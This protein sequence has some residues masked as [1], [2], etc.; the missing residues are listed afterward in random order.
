MPIPSTIITFYWIMIWSQIHGTCTVFLEY[1]CVVTG[2][3]F[4]QSTQ[5]V[6]Y[7]KSLHLLQPFSEYVVNMLCFQKH[8]IYSR[9]IINFQ[10][11]ITKYKMI[12]PSKSYLIN[13]IKDTVDGIKEVN[14]HG[15]QRAP[16]AVQTCICHQCVFS[17]GAEKPTENGSDYDY[18]LLFSSSRIS[19]PLLQAMTLALREVLSSWPSSL[20]RSFSK[21]YPFLGIATSCP[22]RQEVGQR[23]FPP[24]PT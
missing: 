1:G 14:N 18:K 6:N 24:S 3:R 11:S 16:S 13:K 10:E 4:L 19:V 12:F 7:R 22:L 23:S 20:A 15:E 17:G 2:L 8:I 9:Q 21:V 5:P